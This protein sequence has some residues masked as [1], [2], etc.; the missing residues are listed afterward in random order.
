[1]CSSDPMR[2]EEA[3][4]SGGVEVEIPAEFSEYAGVCVAGEEVNGVGGECGPRSGGIRSRIGVAASVC[5][6][7]NRRWR[8]MRIDI[9]ETKNRNENELEIWELEEK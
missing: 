2:V 6:V 4:R 3:A 7:H 5:I 1:M 9:S 8:R